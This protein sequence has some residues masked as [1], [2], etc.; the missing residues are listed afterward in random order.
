MRQHKAWFVAT[1]VVAVA[2]YALMWVAYQNWGW[3]DTADTSA[4]GVLR[5][6]GVTHPGWVRFWDVLSTVVSPAGF[7]LLGAVTIIV[8]IVQ[9]NLRAALFVLLSMELSGFVTRIAKTL[10]DRARPPGALAGAASSS[11][12]SGHAV[13]VMVGLLALWTVA[14]GLL[15]PALRV[16]AIV[17]G[18]L[19]IF[20][21]GFA[22]VAL[23]VHHP[24]DVLA[25][26]ALGYLYF[27]VCLL[28]V[29]P[30]PLRRL[31]APAIA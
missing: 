19:V 16:P 11:F 28:A 26:W 23:N 14:S 12:P 2:V 24:S 4:L 3:L 9:R 17:A 15:R 27:L 10:A 30:V 1:A 7:R 5:D 29:R 21:V 13:A 18:L 22:R 31:G 8:A 25:G 20:A 6:Y